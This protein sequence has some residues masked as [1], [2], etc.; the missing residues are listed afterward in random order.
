MFA[1]SKFVIG[2]QKYFPFLYY[3]LFVRIFLKRPSSVGSPNISL[4]RR[5]CSFFICTFHNVILLSRWPLTALYNW[6]DP[7]RG[8][9]IDLYLAGDRQNV[10]RSI[11]MFV[12]PV[13]FTIH[14]S[15][16]SNKKAFLLFH[17]V[18]FVFP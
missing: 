14:I 2:L 11:S 16:H 12:L 5:L 18:R 1:C 3:G 4:P 8:L 15:H 7:L 10:N 6:Q 9:N 17:A 13:Y